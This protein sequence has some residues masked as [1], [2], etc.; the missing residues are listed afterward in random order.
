MMIRVE[1]KDGKQH[2][3]YLEYRDNGKLEQERNYANGEWQLATLNAVGVGLAVVFNPLTSLFTS[4]KRKPVQEIAEST[5]TGSATTI[6][7]GL[8]VGMEASVW[9]LLAIV[10]ALGA[11]GLMLIGIKV[12]GGNDAE[13]RVMQ[14]VITGMGFIG[15]FCHLYIGQEAV[16][17]GADQDELGRHLV[18]DLE[19]L[20][21]DLAVA[22]GVDHGQIGVTAAG[23]A[24]GVRGT[25]GC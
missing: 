7:S 17:V 22:V 4:I 15:G 16:V 11:C 13:G 8:A 9:S 6:L 24:P 10:V 23:R 25:S 21:L 5:Q 18:D 19:L 1:Y 20:H 14:A 3:K 2:G 12:M